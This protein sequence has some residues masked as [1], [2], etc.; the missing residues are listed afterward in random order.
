MFFCKKPFLL[1]FSPSYFFLL[2]L[3]VYGINHYKPVPWK[4]PGCVHKAKRISYNMYMRSLNATNHG[5][6]ASFN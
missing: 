1:R 5:S 6:T 4:Y 3:A 2:S